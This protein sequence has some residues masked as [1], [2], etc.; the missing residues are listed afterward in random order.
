ML[1]I[2]RIGSQTPEFKYNQ[3]I[4]IVGKRACGKTKYTIEKILDDLKPGYDGT[5]I[6]SSEYIFDNEWKEHGKRVLEEELGIIRDRV[7]DYNDKMVLIVDGINYN[8]LSKNSRKILDGLF[9]N[10]KSNFTMVYISQYVLHIPIQFRESYDYFV[11]SGLT[12]RE[13]DGLGV[14]NDMKMYVR[15]LIGRLGNYEFGLIDNYTLSNLEV[16][17]VCA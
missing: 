11:F 3:S 15:S 14:E 6:F 9:G 2:T 8:D 5:Y 13:I 16:L 17:P 10:K 12:E 4:L 7:N 1:N